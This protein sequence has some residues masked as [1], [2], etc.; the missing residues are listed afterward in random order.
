MLPLPPG[1]GRGEGE[2]HVNALEAVRIAFEAMRANKFRAFLTMLGVVIGVSSIILL[3]SIGE[4]AKIYITKQFMDVGTNIL[5]V[6]PGKQRTSGGPMTG[7]STVYKLTFED[8][9]AL[10]RRCPSVKEVAPIMFAAAPVKYRNR[11][12]DT[13]ILGTTYPFQDVRN[14]HVE[15]GKFVE[16]RGTAKPRGRDCVLGR[17]VK[18]DL[19]GSRN[20]LGEFV[21][22]NES[23]F[24]V[25]GIMERKGRSLG[26]DIDDL[27][28]IPIGSA[29]KLFNTQ[30]LFEVLA[31]ARSAEAIPRAEEEIAKV[32][33]KRHHDTEGFTLINQAELL[34]TFGTILTMLT[35]VLAG[36]AG[37]SLFVGGI[38]IM[39]ILL[40]SVGERTK[41]IGI[42]KA[43][44][45]KR[46]DILGQ[47]LTESAAISLTGGA[48]GIAIGWGG[49]WL[50]NAA[51]PELPT[52]V[53]SWTV[54]LAFGFSLGV[55]L[56]FGVYP[57]RKAAMLHPIDALRYE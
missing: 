16:D 14:L 52:S 38:G 19:F 26:F 33:K 34:E 9:M 6:L 24:R 32:L 40:V 25:I 56:F 31:T 7:A 53:S 13:S 30:S 46:R 4:G 35:Y 2:A 21:R 50:V 18:E 28:F 10:K 20:P 44:G 12:R 17:R 29:E 5:V 45:A 39:N 37:I 41:E 15:V 8:A 3:V 47:F 43:V 22:I 55:G 51:V 42:R 11:K 57:A 49:A 48:I 54:A 1:E 36:I 27:V 23:R